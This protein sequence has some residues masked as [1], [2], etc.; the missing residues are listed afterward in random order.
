MESQPSQIGDRI[1]LGDRLFE[2]GEYIEAARH[3]EHILASDAPAALQAWAKY[4]LAAAMEHMGKYAQAQKLFEEIRQLDTRA[5]EL[6][7]TI[8]SA[9]TAVLD[10]LS[11][12]EQSSTRMAHEQTES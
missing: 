11:L 4:R 3:Y 7:H 2:H 8:R 1:R 9:A 10:E 5:T 12:K 6:E